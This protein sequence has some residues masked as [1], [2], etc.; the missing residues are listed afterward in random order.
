MEEPGFK[1]N[2]TLV[3]QD[4]EDDFR[5]FTANLYSKRDRT[6]GVENRVTPVVCFCVP[7][8]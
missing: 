6:H 4:H 2:H 3:T 1:L 5:G 8:Q 7:C